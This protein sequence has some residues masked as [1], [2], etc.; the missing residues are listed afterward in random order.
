[1]GLK[2]L[3]DKQKLNTVL[4]RNTFNNKKYPRGKYYANN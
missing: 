1:M 3:T 4:K 2:S